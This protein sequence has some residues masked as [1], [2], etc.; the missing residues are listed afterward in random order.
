MTRI[1]SVAEARQGYIAKRHGETS[2][3]NGNGLYPNCVGT[4]ENIHLS[5]LLELCS[6]NRHSLVLKLYLISLFFK[7]NYILISK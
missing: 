2:G 4:F 5:K 6:L 1:T 3:G 7:G